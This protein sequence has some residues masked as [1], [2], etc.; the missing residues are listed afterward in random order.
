MFFKR[1][2]TDWKN[3]SVGLFFSV[4]DFAPMQQDRQRVLTVMTYECKKL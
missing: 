3:K 1:K 2:R 4:N